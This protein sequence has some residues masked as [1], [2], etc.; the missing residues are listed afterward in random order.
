[1]SQ[2]TNVPELAF[3]RFWTYD[4]LDAFCHA[5]AGARPDLVQL[6][7]LATSREGRAIQLLTI[8]D[9]ATGTAVTVR[10][11][12]YLLFHTARPAAGLFFASSGQLSRCL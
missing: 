10:P 12:V 8:T 9:A 1:M 5:L 6:S 11:S 3:Q 2:T 4:E 7:T